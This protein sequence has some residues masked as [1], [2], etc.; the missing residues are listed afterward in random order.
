MNRDA[1]NLDQVL[2]E[3]L[4]GIREERMPETAE[5]AAVERVWQRVRDEAEADARRRQAEAAEAGEVPSIQGAHDEARRWLYQDP[6]SESISRGRALRRTQVSQ[7]KRSGG[8]MPEWASRWGWRAAAAAVIFVALV[9]ITF[10][11]DLLTIKTGGLVVIEAL[12]GEA[13][14]QNGDG[15]V[16]SVQSGDRIQLGRGDAIV[17]GKSTRMMLRTPDG[18]GVEVAPRSEVGLVQARLLGLGR[19]DSVVEL[20]RGNIIVEASEQGSGHFYVNTPDAQVAVTGTVF[21]VNSGMKGSRVTVIE[22][23]V[24]VDQ[25]RREDV[26]HPGQQVTT[27]DNLAHVPVEQEISW[28]ANLE[29]H[30]ALLREVTELGRELDVAL[31]QDLRYSTDLLDATPSTT[32]IYVGAPNLARSADEAY[33]VLVAKVASSTELK[34][35]WD[36]EVA[37]DGT[38][39]K[40]ERVLSEIGQFG[41][42]LGDEISLAVLPAAEPEGTHVLVL[43][44]LTQPGSFPAF[45]ESKLAAWSAEADDEDAA[46]LLER[47]RV[48]AAGDFAALTA[49]LA[50]TDAADA[51][52]DA[53]GSR[54]RLILWVRNDLLVAGPDL[55]ALAAVDARLAGGAT[56]PAAADSFRGRLE[57]LYRDGAEWVVGVDLE[58]LMDRAAAGSESDDDGDVAES[59]G[60]LDMQHLIAEQKSQDGSTVSRVKLGFDRPRRGLAGWLDEPAP[61]GAL[62]YVS[63]DALLAGGF[64]IR[65]PAVLVDELFQILGDVNADFESSLAEFEAEKGI[66]VRRDFAAP[67]GGEFAFALEKPVAPNPSWK[68]V[69]EV[70]DPA[71][72]QRA[73]EWA[74]EE[75]NRGAREGGLAL[76][77][78]LVRLER[79]DS[80]GRASYRVFN[81][82]TGL[83]AHY[84]FV[85]GYLIAG[86]SRV[87]LD[88]AV[89]TRDSGY[90]LARSE[91]FQS[92]LPT[93]RQN[94]FSGVL[95]QNLGG[96]IENLAAIAQRMAG[97]DN[98]LTQALALQGPSL[99]VA[100]GAERDITFVYRREGGIF[101][102]TIGSFFNLKTLMDLERWKEPGVQSAR[103]T[104]HDEG[105]ILLQ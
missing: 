64:V 8:G 101:G 43:A 68:L 73:I 10:Q 38:D 20:G 24:A 9:G 40:I 46:A 30:L 12:D 78:D 4:E 88:D 85:G 84:T 82:A 25:A 61:I 60:L 34:S 100:Y 66:D 92:L 71:A 35:W 97:E 57:A 98:A 99:S 41:E 13:Y 56:A 18:S 80:A 23:E 70:Y 75:A 93:D 59:M 47:V 39:A 102:G 44:R 15:T 62:E 16:E 81:P 90:S 58:T 11:S 17:T 87:Q 52:G 37:A 51:A 27:S 33:D 14:R 72:L 53:T 48:V 55:E 96:A 49:G 50:A 19:P 83:S 105:M 22:G 2:D 36:A 89:R 95:Y 74:I 45:V 54:E 94:N 3:A 21:A 5:R 77:D 103:S 29:R 67:L 26:L 104:P 28:S 86:S 42:Q 79:T 1:R 91:T 32:A 65:D 6:L 76:Q 31:Q 69:M 7:P 63:A